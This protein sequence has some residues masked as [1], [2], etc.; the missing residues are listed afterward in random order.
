[1]KGETFLQQPFTELI[2]AATNTHFKV[3]NTLSL[4]YKPDAFGKHRLPSKAS[5]FVINIFFSFSLGKLIAFVLE[6]MLRIFYRLL[7]RVSLTNTEEIID[8]PQTFS[9][10]KN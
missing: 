2:V 9:T 8:S 10:Q 3:V 1:M 7:K 5:K 4:A 6:G